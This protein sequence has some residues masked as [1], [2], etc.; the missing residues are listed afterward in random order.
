L[1]CA[2][3][4]LAPVLYLAVGGG[5]V[6]Q[7]LLTWLGV[8]MLISGLLLR[9]QYTRS[10]FSRILVTLGVSVFLLPLLAPFVLDDVGMSLAD[11]FRLIGSA[12]TGRETIAAVAELVPFTL[13]LMSLIAWLPG[14]GKAMSGVLAWVFIASSLILGVLSLAAGIDPAAGLKTG[15][16]TYIYLPL[17]QTAWVAMAAYGMATVFGKSLERAP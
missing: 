11:R 14:P 7:A 6:W 15:L 8:V 12:T 3:L 4:G 2:L 10:I 17:A 16:A 13:A 5:F 1:T 9:S